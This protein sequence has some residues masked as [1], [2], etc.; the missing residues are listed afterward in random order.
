MINLHSFSK[1]L[2]NS[3]TISHPIA[4]LLIA[5]FLGHQSCSP[6]RLE[7]VLKNMLLT[8]EEKLVTLAAGGDF[9]AFEQL[10]EKYSLP[11]ARFV[12]R[13]I[14]HPEDARDAVQQIL[15]LVYQGLPGLQDPAHFRGWLFKIARNKSFEILRRRSFPGAENFANAGLK[16]EDAAW[17]EE[18]T[19][20]ENLVPDPGPLPL[21]LVERQETRQLLQAAIN[22]LPERSRQVVILRYTT[23]LTFGEIA[24]VL[25][26][27]ENTVKTL[28]QRGKAWLRTYLI[29]RL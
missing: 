18:T 15:I 24:Q 20:L 6:G 11:L 26:T 17:D 4:S 1:K 2:P 27:N 8:N 3:E 16:S 12:T 9:E 29:E 25:D 5:N 22:R 10:V 21:E 14:G 7:K 28:F 23:D 13:L 19:T